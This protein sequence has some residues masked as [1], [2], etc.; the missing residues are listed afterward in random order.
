MMGRYPPGTVTTS[1]VLM[2]DI[3]DS[4]PTRIRLG[5][6]AA[7]RHFQNAYQLMLAVVHTAHATFTRSRGDGLVAVFDSVTAG[8]DAA[9]ALEQELAAEN[10]HLPEPITIRAALSVGDV[11]WSAN[12]VEGLPLVHAARLMDMADGDEVLCTDMA[13][14]LASRQPNH[15]F[16]L[17]GPRR[18]KGLDKPLVV[19][20]FLW[21]EVTPPQRLPPWLVIAQQAVMVGRRT[22]LTILQAELQHATSTVRR[23]HVEA[24][25]G[26]GK[27]RL[28]AKLAEIAT[29][30][31][32]ILMTS[33]CHRLARRAHE[34]ISA[35]ITHLAHTARVQLLRAGVTPPDTLPQA[36]IPTHTDTSDEA[37]TDFQ[38]DA[39][40][41]FDPDSSGPTREELPGPGAVRPG[42]H[43]AQLISD[44]S[45]LIARLAEL[46]PVLLLIDDLQWAS[47][48]SLQI[49]QGLHWDQPPRLLVLTA[50]RPVPA[51]SA[52]PAESELRRLRSDSRVTGI[53][54]LTSPDIQELIAATPLPSPPATDPSTELNIGQ[55]LHL[56]GGNAFLVNEVLREL[57]SGKALGSLDVQNLTHQV[58]KMR[59][60][61]LSE[62]ARHVAELL[63]VGERLPSDVLRAAAELTEAQFADVVDELLTRGLIDQIQY[64][65]F[66]LPHEL[67]RR[68]IYESLPP[69]RLGA[70]HGQIADLLMKFDSTINE[71]GPYVVASHLVA[72]SEQG[73]DVDRTRQAAE[74][75]QQAAQHAA[76]KLAY[77]EAVTWYDHHLAQLTKNP[78]T[79]AEE[80][81]SALAECGQAMWLAGDHRARS[82]LNRAAD[83]ARRC[84]RAD[85][86][87][88]AASAGDRGFFSITAGHDGD[89]IALL[90]EALRLVGT[91]AGTT[92]ALLL[93][94]L[95]SELTWAPEGDQRFSLSDT[96]LAL[97]RQSGDPATLVSVLGLRSLTMVPTLSLE[98]RQ[99]EA[100]EML[101]AADRT[102][103]DLLRFH[104]TFQKVAPVLDTGNTVDIAR[105]LTKAADLAQR[106]A[107]PHL[108]WLIAFSQAG[109]SLMRGDLE[110]AQHQAWRARQ[111]GREIGRQHEADPFYGEQ[112]AEIRRLRGQL[113]TLRA[114]LRDAIDLSDMDPVHSI[115]RFLCEVGD[116]AAAPL[117]D[118]I[119][120]THGVIPRNDIAFRPALDNLAIGATRLNRTDLAEPLY[121][122]L[123]RDAD[124]LG[125]SAVAHHCGHH[126]LA[127]LA[128]TAGKSALAAEHFEAAAAVHERCGI[129]LLTA[130]SL[131]DWADLAAHDPRM[132]IPPR[133]HEHCRELIAGRGATLL[134]DR[135]EVS[136]ERRIR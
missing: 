65:R 102:G 72:A 52:E 62:R 84:Q 95:A 80:V 130:E 6:V 38:P 70:L 76:S 112:L 124:T 63:A 114:P 85:L 64:L 73:H 12:E 27:T 121:Q 113:D 48:E 129:P 94:Q 132:S 22:E 37:R 15:A 78:R 39:Q 5:E 4:T 91:S 29:E 28:L 101:D 34:P 19:H 127:H 99:R 46:R 107:Q 14:A 25:Q 55:I 125:H 79:S 41:D 59:L 35:A 47:A 108:H 17:L 98:Q 45:M 106:L 21:Q 110:T 43:R 119:I 18:A 88:T 3:V 68:P 10:L 36:L 116:E 115:L 75:S 58:I 42:A 20:R 89:R 13:Q 103:D 131:L 30:Q 1:T 126:Y 61:Q 51:H 77:S 120:A 128:A 117:L 86:V 23:V 24:D 83:H 54:P 71:T 74:A 123:K 16:Q 135:W 111:L 66:Q 133:L 109:L 96:A 81:A 57:N 60:E 100:A 134:E 40:A 9:L 44:I 104:A 49:L 118:Q 53:Q 87:I 50:S 2:V 7:D 67:V 69:A 31:G 32:F 136:N 93:A 33:R 11:Q 56:T 92:R 8:F 82:I 105:W 90:E 97:A 122:A 26:E